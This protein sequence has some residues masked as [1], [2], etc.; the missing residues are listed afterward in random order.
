[1]GQVVLGRSVLRLREVHCL[2]GLTFDMGYV[3]V[4]NTLYLPVG[5]D[6]LAHRRECGCLAQ[7]R[8]YGRWVQFIPRVVKPVRGC[9]LPE[10]TAG[11]RHVTIYKFTPKIKVS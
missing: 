5:A 4:S 9:A 11:G 10:H 2:A 8:K 6:C 1:M 3:A 7:S